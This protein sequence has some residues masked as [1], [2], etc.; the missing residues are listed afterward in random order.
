MPSKVNV[1]SIVLYYK[2]GEELCSLPHVAS[3]AGLN[4]FLL[5]GVRHGQR[6]GRSAAVRPTTNRFVWAAGFWMGDG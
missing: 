1:R 4:R 5:A 3:R 6:R 2:R